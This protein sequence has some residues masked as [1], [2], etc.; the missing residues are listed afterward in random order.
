[1]PCYTVK[2][3]TVEFKVKNE[4]VLK[5]VLKKHFNYVESSKTN[6]GTIFFYSYPGQTTS[7]IDLNAQTAQVIS[8]ININQVKKEYAKEI[9][10]Q[11]AEK[12]KWLFK[13]TADNKIQLNKY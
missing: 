8:G 10:K 1:M 6:P 11:V 3:I 7:W 12:K 2:L 9:I 13:Q 5:K 4:E